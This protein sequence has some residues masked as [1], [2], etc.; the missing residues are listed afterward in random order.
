VV[1]GFELAVRLAK[2]AFEIPKEFPAPFAK[3]GFRENFALEVLVARVHLGL[4]GP[5]VCP[6]FALLRKSK[7]RA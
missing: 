4:Q 7:S 5:V 6:L 3:L 2:F 1:A